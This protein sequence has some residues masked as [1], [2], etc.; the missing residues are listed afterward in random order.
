MQNVLVDKRQVT[1]TS[2]ERVLNNNELAQSYGL[3]DRVVDEYRK[4]YCPRR[5]LHPV[6]L[7]APTDEEKYSYVS[8]GRPFLVTC[9]TVALL[10]LGVGAW[11]F[12]KASP[13]YSWYALY[14]YISE[15]YLFT[16]LYITVVGKEFDVDK[17]EE[18]VDAFQIVEET[19]RT[20]DIYL[21]VCNES[22]EILEN[23][24][25]HVS[26]L[27]YP[28]KK[29]LVFI[30]DDG[31][32]SVVHSLAQRYNFK[33]ICRW[34]RPLLKKAGSLRRAFAQTSSHFFI[35]FDAVFV[36]DRTSFWILCHTTLPTP[37]W[38]SY[39]QHHV[40]VLSASKHG[41]SKAPGPL[42]S[43]F[44]ASC[45]LAVITCYHLRR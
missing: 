41:L 43:M 10:S 14:I 24:C 23:T 21:P 11:Q 31:A 33:S 17:H 19:A 15:F 3:W 22:L 39:R 28:E 45:N 2:I 37:S 6:L 36:L 5:S 1:N 32:D 26:A 38:P 4:N 35:I 7:T 40:S 20:T 16:S 42:W 30:L 27:E 25:T 9:T 34:D 18:I 13:I 8:M 44:F 29:K 12:S